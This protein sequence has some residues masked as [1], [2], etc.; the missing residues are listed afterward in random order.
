MTASFTNSDG[1]KIGKS[2]KLEPATDWSWEAELPAKV[3]DAQGDIKAE[4]TV[5]FSNGQTAQFFSDFHYT[6]GGISIETGAPWTNLLG[7]ASHTGGVTD[8]PIDTLPALSSVTNIGAN[9]FM[10]SPLIADG[11][12]F[13]ATVDED[14]RGEAAVVAL[15]LSDGS[16]AWR[17]PMEGSVKNSIAI[18]S[19]KV[20]AQYVN[21]KLY[22]LNCSDGSI[23]WTR[24]LDVR[25]VPALIEGLCANETTVFAGTGHGLA[26]FDSK[27]GEIIWKNSEW[28]QGEG[29]TTTLSE[30]AGVVV[31]GVQ[32][33]AL[34][35]N[36]A[37]DGKLL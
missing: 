10:T 16:I 13:I 37:S 15:N 24:Q 2:I 35:A 26:A 29:T 19:G 34:Y 14:A 1:R 20:F 32:W 17:T 12:T 28:G 21:G 6:T 7:N 18:S 11:K 5:T 36:S 23:A 33:S 9:I 4:V 22:A 31:S 8:A 27:T 25:P 3:I 30:G